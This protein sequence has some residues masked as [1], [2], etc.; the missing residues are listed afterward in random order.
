MARLAVTEGLF[1]IIYATFFA[2]PSEEGGVALATEEV[3][4]KFARP[5]QPS[6][7]RAIPLTKGSVNVV[8]ERIAVCGLAKVAFSQENDG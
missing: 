1:Y 5:C 3:F 6:P 2:F 7:G 4:Y 8:D